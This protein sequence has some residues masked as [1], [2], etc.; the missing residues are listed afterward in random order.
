MSNIQIYMIVP[1]SVI[2]F[3][4]GCSGSKANTQEM[5]ASRNR[6]IALFKGISNLGRRW[7]Y[8]P[9]TNSRNYLAMKAFKGQKG[10]WRLKV[11]K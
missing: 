9:R 5:S 11:L 8:C 3:W 1:L 7:T 6:K 2:K 10:K 4:F